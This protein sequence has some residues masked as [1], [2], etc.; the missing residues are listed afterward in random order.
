MVAD[1]IAAQ[2]RGYGIED[3][4]QTQSDAEFVEPGRQAPDRQS[5]VGVWLA[6]AFRQRAQRAVDRV[7]FGG[8]QLFRQAEK[9]FGEHHLRPPWRSGH[10]R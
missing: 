7:D 2:Q 6:P 9:P 4:A 8:S 3:D 10:R 1:E 5:V